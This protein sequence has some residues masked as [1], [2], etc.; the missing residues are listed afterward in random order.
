MT[1]LLAPLFELRSKSIEI[2]S[3]WEKAKKGK[4]EANPDGV[5]KLFFYERGVFQNMKYPRNVWERKMTTSDGWREE[6]R[7][8]MPVMIIPDNTCYAPPQWLHGQGWPG[9]SW[10]CQTMSYSPQTTHCQSIPRLNQSGWK[11]FYSFIN[12]PE[13]T[14]TLNRGKRRGR[15]KRKRKNH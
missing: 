15:R 3:S 4:R 11:Y 14:Y 6:R 7:G 10:Q 12:C 2:V 8:I 13:N 1:S 5:S 9:L